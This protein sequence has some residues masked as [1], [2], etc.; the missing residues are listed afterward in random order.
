MITDIDVV[1][2]LYLIF[3]SNADLIRHT[4]ALCS[5]QLWLD[6]RLPNDCKLSHLSKLTLL[7][8]TIW[9]NEHYYLA[10]FHN[11]A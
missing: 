1:D 11:S 8:Q 3:S 5:W 6:F 4:Y 9:S 2:Y 10:K 7:H